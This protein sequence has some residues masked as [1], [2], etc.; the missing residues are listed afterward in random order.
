MPGHVPCNV[1]GLP[2]CY[3][4]PQG[5]YCVTMGAFP[6]SVASLS[7]F[8]GARI[9][10]YIR[11]DA[12][13]EQSDYIDYDGTL[14]LHNEDPTARRST[15]QRPPWPI[16]NGS[17][18]STGFCSVRTPRYALPSSM[19]STAARSPPVESGAGCRAL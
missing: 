19:M 8:D 13:D 4:L 9:Y 14:T 16:T 1:Y 3:L 6:D 10:S 5:S 7:V 18:N 15:S 11:T 17:L 12:T 2:S